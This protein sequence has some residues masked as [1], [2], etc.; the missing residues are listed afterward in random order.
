MK[1]LAASVFILLALFSL[2][3]VDHVWAWGARTHQKACSDA[4]FI[5]PAA[6]RE[7]LGARGDKHP[8]LKGLLEAS[9][10]PDRVLKDFRNHVYHLHGYEMGNGPFQIDKLVK[11]VAEDIRTNKPRTLIVQKLGWIAHYC[12]DLLQPLHTGVATWEGIEEKSYHAAF[13]KDCDKF[14]YTFAVTFYGANNVKR[15]SA[16]QVYEAL[17]AN[18]YYEAIEQA[19]TT[20]K[21]FEAVDKIAE[22]TYSRGVNNIVNMW[23]TAWA[24]AGGKIN[25]KVDMKPKF[26]PA[27]QKPG[28]VGRRGA[29]PLRTSVQGEFA[30]PLTDPHLAPIEE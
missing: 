14:V 22:A 8:A 7:F 5:M 3:V 10:E 25:P 20:G 11:E 24:M 2:T 19:Y 30:D 26:F 1:R 9:L 16:R 4:Y 12:A 23:Y 13:E 18:R 21:R 29:N 28:D 27:L 15:I 6:F 17:W